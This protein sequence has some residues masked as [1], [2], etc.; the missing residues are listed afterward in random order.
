M[1]RVTLHTGSTTMHVPEDVRRTTSIGPPQTIG[2]ALLQ[3]TRPLVGASLLNYKR[4]QPNSQGRG[5]SCVSSPCSLILTLAPVVTCYI[6]QYYNQH[7]SGLG[8]NSEQ[9]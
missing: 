5:A 7:Y 2:H 6:E 3:T 8:H 9:V 4:G 1:D